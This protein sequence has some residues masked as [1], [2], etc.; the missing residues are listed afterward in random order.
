V[1]TEGAGR[2]AVFRALADPTRRRILDLLRQEA[3]TTGALAE[4]F[5][6]SRYAVMKHLEVLT[7]AGLVIVERRGRERYN[8]LNAVPLM[9]MYERWLRPY[10]AEWAGRLGRLRRSAEGDNPSRRE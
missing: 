7:E 3:M 1:S 8:H 5:P 6:V 10:E 2:D 9:E 4:Q